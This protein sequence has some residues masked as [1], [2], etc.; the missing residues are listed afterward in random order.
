[1]TLA[2]KL[3]AFALF[4]LSLFAL[5]ACASG[6]TT[7]ELTVTDA[8][9]KATD[10]GMTAGFATINN[11]GAREARIVGATTPAASFVELHETITDAAGQA[12]MREAADG[13]VVPVK[14]SVT[15]EP[16]GSHLMLMDVSEAL[17]AGD[18]VTLTLQF[19]SGSPISFVA[20]VKDFA[21]ANETYEH[22][23]T[24]H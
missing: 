4:G 13:I 17:K 7:T 19:D 3:A 23:H 20:V 6:Q 15:L 21:G 22:D 16:G 11:P 18:E 5:G 12:V 10:G 8:W 24:D 2:R 1:M 14:S 9:V